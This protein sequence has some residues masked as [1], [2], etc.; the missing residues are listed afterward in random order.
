MSS[1]IR[2]A[3]GYYKEIMY[4]WRL[5]MQLSNRRP[6]RGPS[7]VGYLKSQVRLEGASK[8]MRS[9]SRILY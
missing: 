1:P 7:C 8:G 6:I 2:N 3:N 5:R 4:P 9:S